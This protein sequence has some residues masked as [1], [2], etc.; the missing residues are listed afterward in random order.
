MRLELCANT[1]KDE[2]YS[3]WRRPRIIR[4]YKSKVRY[5]N[6]GYA[7]LWRILW[8][9]LDFMV[10]WDIADPEPLTPSKNVGDVYI[11]ST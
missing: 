8:W 9:R 1:Y 7:N 6:S 2:P 5:D 11:S 10:E 4:V 3:F